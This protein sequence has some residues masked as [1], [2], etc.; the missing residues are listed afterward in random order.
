MVKA[1]RF[2]SLLSVA[3][4]MSACSQTAA[5]AADVTP[6]PAL[7]VAGRPVIATLVTHDSKAAI[8]GGNG[9][10]LRVVVRS[11]NGA[12]SASGADGVTLDELR[13]RDPELYEIVTSSFAANGYVDATL[14]LNHLN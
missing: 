7:R 8:L 4:G 11:A 1:A 10:D 13:A 2:A 9:K 14:D 12:N 5:P 6:T 3:M